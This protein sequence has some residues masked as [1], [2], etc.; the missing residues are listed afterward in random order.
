VTCAQ[1]Q[2]GTAG[3]ASVRYGKGTAVTV[4]IKELLAKNAGGSTMPPGQ[5]D[6]ASS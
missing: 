2:D 4:Y 5:E 3:L 1:W 6:A